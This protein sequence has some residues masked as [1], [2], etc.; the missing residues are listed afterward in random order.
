MKVL[1]ISYRD[2]GGAGLCAYRLHK[3][4]QKHGIDSSM[5]VMYKSQP[6]DSVH[7]PYKVFVFAFRLL[8][9]LL[10]R[11]GLFIF[12]SDKLIKRSNEQKSCF[13]SPVGPI[14]LSSHPLVKDVDIIHIHWADAFFDQPKFFKRVAKPIVWT[15][16]DESFFYGISHYHDEV[17]FN[18]PLESKY[19]KVKVDM[20]QHADNVSI[21]L[22]SSYFYRHFSTD[23]ILKDKEVCIINN[24]VD[25]SHFVKFDR[26]EARRVLGL[27]ERYKYL[28]FVAAD[29]SDRHKALNNLVDAV[30]LMGD[31]NIR[32]IAIGDNSSFKKN[33]MVIDVGKVY[34]TKKLSRYLSAA[35]FFVMPS[36]QEAFSQ[37]PIEA[38]ACGTPVIS[39]PVSGIDECVKKENGVICNGFKPEDIATGL[40]KA[41]ETEYDREI[42]RNS[43]LN[44][45]SRGKITQQYVDVYEKLL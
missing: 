17:D 18:D 7:V 9:G 13:T 34:D 24:F 20:M 43:V 8:H 35:D 2:G 45:F 41:F 23:P 27:D 21:V 26:D 44:K 40:R 37:A 1:H 22:L 36:L 31:E 19:R 12:E 33:E 25:S 38:M 5:L 29:I 14:D 16:H 42:I 30:L 39:T 6:D 10:R 28:V 3:E 32:I 15:I 4:L 11:L